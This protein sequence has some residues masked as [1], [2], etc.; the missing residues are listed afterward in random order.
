MQLFETSDPYNRI[1]YTF[2]FIYLIS[3]SYIATCFIL[4]SLFYLNDKAQG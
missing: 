4:N 3:L 1:K 2:I